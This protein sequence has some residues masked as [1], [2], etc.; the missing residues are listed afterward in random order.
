LSE[1]DRETILNIVPEL[2]NKKLFR[3]LGNEVMRDSISML[4]MA[5][6]EA[7]IPMTHDLLMFLH[8][9]LEK[10]IKH[11]YADTQRLGA[12]AMEKLYALTA[13]TE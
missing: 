2:D 1:K 10:T 13:I 12:V 8:S 11:P 4:I 7:A 3:G 9:H 6:C 5:I